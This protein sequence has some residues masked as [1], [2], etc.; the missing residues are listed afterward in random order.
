MFQYMVS[1]RNG[2]N[3][4]GGFLQHIEQRRAD[5]A[6]RWGIVSEKQGSQVRGV[7]CMLGNCDWQ[8]KKTWHLK[9]LFFFAGDYFSET[10]FIFSQVSF[11]VIFWQY[12]YLLFKPQTLHVV[13]TVFFSP[14]ALFHLG[15]QR[16]KIETRVASPLFTASC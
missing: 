10:I 1:L 6:A 2:C 11:F 15:R 12:K 7:Q 5:A 14:L 8:R 16:R 13:Q 4:R 3:K 9:G